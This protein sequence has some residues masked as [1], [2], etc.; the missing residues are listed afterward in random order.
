MKAILI[1]VG[2]IPRVVE[3][4]GL[5][6]LQSLVEGHIDAVD[7]P[8]RQDLTAYIND[9]GKFLYQRNDVATRLLEL[10]LAR[11]DW[12]AGPCVICGFSPAEGRTLEIPEDAMQLVNAAAAEVYGTS[13]QPGPSTMQAPADDEKVVLV[14]AKDVRRTDVAWH[15]DRSRY[16]VVSR[17]SRIPVAGKV[18]IHFLYDDE[19]IPQALEAD[20]KVRLGAV[21]INA[22]RV[23]DRL[24][25][26]EGKKAGAW[27]TKRFED[28]MFHAGFHPL[29][30]GHEFVAALSAWEEGGHIRLLPDGGNFPF[31]FSLAADLELAMIDYCEGDIAVRV[32][33]TREGYVRALDLYARGPLDSEQRRAGHE[34]LVSRALRAG[35][36]PGTPEFEGGLGATGK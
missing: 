8:L 25:V 36:Y 34:R 33:D 20:E 22:Q 9:E 29:A 4:D 23:I 32:Y 10:G 15:S 31:S 5:K 3:Q 24:C 1:P 18:T 17:S 16:A 6:D 12:I 13:L 28:H 30:N 19:E 2:G 21:G 11:G 7:F 14:E 27:S 35:V 26:P